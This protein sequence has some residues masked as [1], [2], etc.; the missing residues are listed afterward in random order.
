[1]RNAADLAV[2]LLGGTGVAV[3]PGACFGRPDAFRIS[4]ATSMANLAKGLDRIEQALRA[5]K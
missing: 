1:M 3:V 2:A 4:Y 5:A